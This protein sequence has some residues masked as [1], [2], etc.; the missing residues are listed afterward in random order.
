MLPVSPE[1]S[2]NGANVIL[3]RRAL[4]TLV[5]AEVVA[6]ALASLPQEIVEPY[7]SVTT[8]G[9]VPVRS[10]DA[11]TTA[12]AEAAPGWTAERLSADSARI[13]VE[14]LMKGLWRVILRFTSD[15]ALVART[16]LLYSKTYNVGQLESAIPRPGHAEVV[17]SGWRGITDL[18]IAGLAAGI[19]TVLRCAGRRDA[20][21]AGKRTP[22]GAFFACTWT[23]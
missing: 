20:T 8:V 16:P 10:V 19:E 17:H 6:R 21:V 2:V 1:P 12:V 14:A 5:G 3:S 23:P 9:W 7:T 4:E 18:Q 13:G 11:V 22:T 15:E